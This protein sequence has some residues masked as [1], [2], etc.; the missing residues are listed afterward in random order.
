[1]REMTPMDLN[2]S[3]RREK[4]NRNDSLDREWSESINQTISNQI[5]FCSPVSQA[6]SRSQKM[7]QSEVIDRSRATARFISSRQLG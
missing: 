7:A 6:K 3:R 4:H 2:E 5:Q 1:M